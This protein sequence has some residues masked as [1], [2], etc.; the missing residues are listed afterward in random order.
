MY[1]KRVEAGA[2]AGGGV[3]VWADWM[4]CWW[5]QSSCKHDFTLYW[6]RRSVLSNSIHNQQHFRLHLQR[7]AAVKRHKKY[8]RR[9]R[10][11]R[12][13]KEEQKRPNQIIKN[14]MP[15]KGAT[16]FPFLHVSVRRRLVRAGIKKINKLLPFACKTEWEQEVCLPALP[17]TT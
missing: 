7:W 1:I 16:G 17:T 13:K 15:R 9:S 8:I 11:R 14:N 10:R 5:V 4:L 2:G 12:R 6:M 3:G